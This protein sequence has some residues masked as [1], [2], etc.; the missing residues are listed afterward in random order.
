VIPFRVFGVLLAVLLATGCVAP[1]RSF[2]AFESK[3]VD[4]A[5]SARSDAETA[6]L[7]A[8]LAAQGRLASATTSDMLQE[9]AIGAA[10]AAETFATIQP[11]DPASDALRRELLPELQR[12]A[13]TIALMQIAARRVDVAA[14]SDLI[15]DLRPIA[16]GLERF[17]LDHR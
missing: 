16:D 15:T 12:A 13:D 3:A 1:A 9:A 6:I 5:E 4:S 2:S 17:A 7:A 8:D 14:V 11:P 10:T